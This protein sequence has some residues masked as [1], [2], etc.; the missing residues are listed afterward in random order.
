MA[1]QGTPNA[2]VGVR[3][4]HHPHMTVQSKELKDYIKASLEAIKDGLENTGYEIKDSIEFSIAVTNT[5]ERGGGLKIYVAKAEGKLNS[6]EI[7]HLK[8]KVAIRQKA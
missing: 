6:K 1:V 8:F 2:L 7:S 3:F 4:P 5:K